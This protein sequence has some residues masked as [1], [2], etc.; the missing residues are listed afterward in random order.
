MLTENREEMTDDRRQIKEV[1]KTRDEE[2][3]GVLGKMGRIRIVFLQNKAN[4]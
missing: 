3:L 1:R 2:V 4:L